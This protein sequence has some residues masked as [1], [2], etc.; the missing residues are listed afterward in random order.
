MS[1]VIIAHEE[2]VAN[3]NFNEPSEEEHEKWTEV[4]NSDAHD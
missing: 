4:L 1:Q 3:Q 2:E